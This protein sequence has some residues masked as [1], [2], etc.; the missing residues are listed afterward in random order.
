MMLSDY[1]AV[2]LTGLLIILAAVVAPLWVARRRP[3]RSPR[4]KTDVINRPPGTTNHYARI[5]HRRP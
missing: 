2:S 3:R 1:I 5:D 4:Q